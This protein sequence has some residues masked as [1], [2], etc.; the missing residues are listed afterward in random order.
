MVMAG[1]NLSSGGQFIVTVVFTL[2]VRTSW[3]QLIRY[4]AYQ[5]LKLPSVTAAKLH[6]WSSGENNVWLRVTTT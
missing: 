2:R 4:L 1:E 5:I 3:G 6:L